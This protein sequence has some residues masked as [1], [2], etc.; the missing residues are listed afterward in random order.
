MELWVSLLSAGSGTDGLEGSLPTQFYDSMLDP[1]HLHSTHPD[2]S[3]PVPSCSR[4][5]QSQV[6]L[7]LFPLFFH[8]YCKMTKFG[9][10]PGVPPITQP[11]FLRLCVMVEGM[12][13]KSELQMSSSTESFKL[14]KTTKT[15][16]S[17]PSPPHHAHCVPQCH[18]PTAVEP[19]HGR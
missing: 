7:F 3:T 2:T 9:Q 14:E 8:F 15:T 13:K 18:I 17:N 16:Q 10:C 12:H 11:A 5:T 19:L 4:T 6:P 1:Q